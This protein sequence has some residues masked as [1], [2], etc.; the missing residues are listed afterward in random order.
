MNLQAWGKWGG[1]GRMI[2]E[3]QRA[4]R[5]CIWNL[6]IKNQIIYKKS[7]KGDKLSLWLNNALPKSNKYWIKISVT[8]WRP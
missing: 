8:E 3:T 4:Y 5:K 2:N 1:K 6:Y 7:L